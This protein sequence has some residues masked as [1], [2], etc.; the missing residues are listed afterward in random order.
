LRSVAEARAKYR[1]LRAETEKNAV[2][3]LRFEGTTGSL[4]T[5]ELADQNLVAR[6][7]APAPGQVQITRNEN[8]VLSIG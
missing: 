2:A 7:K 1:K 3:A 4:L 6:L 8:G 5:L